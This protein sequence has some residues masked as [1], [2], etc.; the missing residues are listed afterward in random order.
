MPTKLSPQ[1]SF[2]LRGS[3]LLIGLLTI[4][5]FVLLDPMLYGL[6]MAASVFVGVEERSSGDW[7]LRVALDAT[8]PG[9]DQHPQSQKIGSIDFDMSRSDAIAFT[10][11]LPVFWAIVL[12]APGPILRRLRPLLLGTVVMASIEVL[13]LLGFAQVAAHNVLAQ[14]YGIE[15]AAGAWGRRLCEYL[16]VNVLPYVLPFVVAVCT[17]RQLWR[18]VTAQLRA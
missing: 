16:V 3:G 9:T 13:L 10:F 12:A 15:S 18:A 8:I 6:R 17:D 5:W 2:L 7:R 1:L 14:S 4:W 11:S